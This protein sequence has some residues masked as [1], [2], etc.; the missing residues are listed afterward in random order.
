MIT[1]EVYINGRLM[2][3]SDNTR[4][5]RTYQA[6]NIGEL[7]NRQGD[8]SNQVKFPKT[9]NNR[10]TLESMDYVNSATK[11]PYRVNSA[12]IIQEGID[13]MQEAIVTAIGSDED[14]YTVQ[15]TSGNTSFFSLFPDLKISELSIPGMNH[16][17]DFDTVVN[18]RSNTTGVIYPL[19]DWF[20]NSTDN[21]FTTNQI[22]A[23]YLMP[24]IRIKDVFDAMDELTG[25]T[26]KGSFIDS[27]DYPNLILT[28]GSLGR[29]KDAI[30]KYNAAAYNSQNIIFTP[31][32]YLQEIFTPTFNIYGFN[33][34]SNLY[35]ADSPLFGYFT[36]QGFITLTYIPT[37]TYEN[38]TIDISVELIKIGTGVVIA[39]S[40]ASI[41]DPSDPAQVPVVVLCPFELITINYNLQ[42]GDQY[43]VRFK[44][45]D[46]SID[47]YMDTTVDL[48][49]DSAFRFKLITTIPYK[50]YIPLLEL[51]DVKI[52]EIYQDVMNEYGVLIQTNTFRKEV[53]FNFFEDIQANLGIAK[54]WSHKADPKKCS[55]NYKFGSFGK[56][57]NFLYAP[58]DLTTPGI[59]DSFFTIDD[60]TLPDSKDVVKLK[61][62][63]AEEEF[64][65]QAETFPR[66][67][68][69]T[70]APR[71]F[72]DTNF[73]ILLLE[74]KDT[75][76]TMEYV[77]ADGESLSTNTDI[78]FVRASPLYF[79][80]LIPIYYPTLESILRHTKGIKI[81]LN[82]TPQ[83]IQE[84]NYLIPIYLDVHTPKVS[85]SGYFYLNK[86]E[87]Y[88]RGFTSCELMRL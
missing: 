35:T 71:T 55:I 33:F 39:D 37:E 42:P 49:K 77:D 23:D 61:T 19:I 64:R 56:T 3:L 86:I 29:G 21:A 67:K 47:Y 7:Q 57:N 81:P 65:F 22:R 51:Y 82:L 27:P 62:S 32:G 16:T 66:I 50:S 1:D 69:M 25:F 10:I 36:F 68:A 26:S 41:A 17:N 44:V 31:S 53:Y 76:Y 78:P 2:D 34:N 72:Q 87:N 83:D 9:K 38:R 59:G 43:F 88:Q 74:V 58:D 70:A 60:E 40:V 12:Q 85:V 48:D 18:S 84:L 8:Y 14:E 6:N 11:I 15:F 46:S 30:E 20:D 75:P 52:K 45:E 80:T 5:G 54:K 4:I 13:T 24:C 73:R 63:S 28:P 79:G